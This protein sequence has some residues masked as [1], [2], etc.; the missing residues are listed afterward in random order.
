MSAKEFNRVDRDIARP[1]ADR[2]EEHKAD[3]AA[4]LIYREA[5][6]AA[7]GADPGSV[8]GL[9]HPDTD[10]KAFDATKALADL[11]RLRGRLTADPAVDLKG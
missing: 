1:K 9:P 5:Y 7:Q 4:W 2:F 10:P 11:Q 3:V 6:L 8:V